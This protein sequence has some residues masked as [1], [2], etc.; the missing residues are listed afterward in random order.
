MK[1]SFFS[2]ILLLC[3]LQLL[4][5]LQTLAQITQQCTFP[6]ND[7][8]LCDLFQDNLPKFE[9][10]FLT[11]VSTSSLPS[12]SWAYLDIY[13]NTTFTVNSSFMIDDC[14]IRFG[15]S[16]KIIVTGHAGYLQTKGVHYFGCNGW[17]GIYVDGNGILNMYGDRVEDA[18]NGV[19][20][21][22]NFTQVT[23]QS[24]FFNRNI[25][26]IVV[27]SGIAANAL[28]TGNVFDCTSITYLGGQ[29]TS[30]ISTGL[31]STLTFG[32]PFG[33]SNVVRNKIAG[34]Y[35]AYS[36]LNI[37]NGEFACNTKAGIQALGGRLDIRTDPGLAYANYFKHNRADIIT[38]GTIL[39]V[40]ASQFIECETDNIVS[41]NN[42]NAQPID[43]RWNTF[44][45]VAAC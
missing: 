40:Q 41:K 35:A 29:S 33:A 19:T 42:T 8:T 11:P 5:R 14:S 10:N 27:V 1:K 31:N 34:A 13:I 36:N 28:I 20:I 38:D 26:D 7:P 6:T 32:L 25:T 24:C 39:S 3:L 23:L 12:N 22:S 4:S 44:I 21:A 2:K 17:N 37:R 30:A 15:P 43:L 16:G 18:Q 45:R 9:Y